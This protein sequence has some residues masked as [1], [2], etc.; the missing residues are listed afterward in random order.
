MK[1]GCLE[2]A[3]RAVQGFF[4]ALIALGRT[5]RLS[6]EYEDKAC[7]IDAWVASE[8]LAGETSIQV[9]AQKSCPDGVVPIETQRLGRQGWLYKMKAAFIVFERWDRFIIVDTRKLREVAPT[10][11]VD[12][13]ASSIEEAY[14]SYKIYSRMSSTKDGRSGEDRLF[15]V[16]VSDLYAMGAMSV[17]KVHFPGV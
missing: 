4:N 12:E 1:R 11:M 13:P 8:K 7:G 10:L 15:Y 3:N 16:K 17:A 9:K 14:S 5:V 6:T 2:T